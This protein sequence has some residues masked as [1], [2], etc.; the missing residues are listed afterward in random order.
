MRR[1]LAHIYGVLCRC[2]D[3]FMLLFSGCSSHRTRTKMDRE[4]STHPEQSDLSLAV[5]YHAV[6]CAPT[7]R[8]PNG[9]MRSMLCHLRENI[10]AAHTQ[11]FNAN[12]VAQ[13]GACH[14]SRV[15]RSKPHMFTPDSGLSR[16]W[17]SLVHAQ[18]RPIRASPRHGPSGTALVDIDCCHGNPIFTYKIIV[19]PCHP[20]TILA[21]LGY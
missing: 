8:A 10:A 7:S 12:E 14:A 9:H 1:Q 6:K 2:R 15:D 17:L 11:Y 5:Q 18:A 19:A 16:R 21:F 13:H 3:M 4:A 20:S